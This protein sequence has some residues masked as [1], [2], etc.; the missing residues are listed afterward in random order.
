M[1]SHLIESVEQL[2]EL[3]AAPVDLAVRKERSQLDQYSLEF[4]TLSPFMLLSTANGEGH[5]DCSPRGDH[6]GFVEVLDE[7]TL[8]IPD[9]AGNNRLD[10]LT[11]IIANPEVGLL[12]V[13]PGFLDCLRVNG[14]AQLSNDPELLQRFE[15]NGRLPKSVI[16]VKVRQVFFHCGNA[17][18]RS[19]LWK[20]DTQVER[21]LMPGLG[22]IVHAQ[23][24]PEREAEEKAAFAAKLAARN[25]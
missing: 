2:R 14:T 19:G 5:L 10:S 8:A 1:N 24:D 21:D 22:Q 9:R 7:S 4:I 23:V 12:F 20:V 6:A 17:I 3:Y 11:N 18:N 25:P 13:V 16:L 15:L